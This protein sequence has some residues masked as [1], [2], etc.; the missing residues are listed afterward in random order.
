MTSRIELSSPIGRLS[1]FA[2]EGAITGVFLP[3]QEAPPAPLGDDALLRSARD[4]LEAYFAGTR[5]SFDLPL[6]PRGTVFQQRV[7]AALRAIPFA[8]TISYAELALL[9]GRPGAARAVGTA[10][11][12]NPISVIVPCHRVIGAD[13]ALTGYAGGLEAK[14]W[15]L[16][17][18]RVWSLSRRREKSSGGGLSSAMRSRVRG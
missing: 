17:H 15:L 3:T 10:N 6:S 4:Q 5:V 16:A 14:A 13:G 1:I 7:W 8:E 12:R 9:V 18:E 11:A 2:D